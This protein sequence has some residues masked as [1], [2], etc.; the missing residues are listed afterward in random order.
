MAGRV[1]QSVTVV[2]N[3]VKNTFLMLC[4]HLHSCIFL[5]VFMLKKRK[6]GKKKKMERKKIRTK[7]SALVSLLKD[8]ILIS[9]VCGIALI[10]T[11]TEIKRW[12]E[13][14]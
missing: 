9:P 1:N 6:K 12:N 13:E 8:P 4:S 7:S 10:F 2:V 5:F 3:E 14:L 11:R